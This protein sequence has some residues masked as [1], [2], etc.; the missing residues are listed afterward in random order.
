MI[1]LI[2]SIRT[3]SSGEDLKQREGP[4]PSSDERF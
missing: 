2:W 1:A 3:L 4:P